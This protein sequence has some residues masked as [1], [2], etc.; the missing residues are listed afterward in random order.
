MIPSIISAD[1][2]TFA[3]GAAIAENIRVKL[4]SGVLQVA[5]STERSIGTTEAAVAI[6]AT[7]SVR[8]RTSRG[9]V[10][11]T[12][13]GNINAGQDVY[14]S[15]NGRVAASGTVFEGTALTGASIGE[16]IEVV[17]A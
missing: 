17:R 4:S 11:M 7:V 5:G 10:L 1:C 9:T 2:R 14:A 8:L 13:G 15:S 6:G 3:S 12:A 16:T